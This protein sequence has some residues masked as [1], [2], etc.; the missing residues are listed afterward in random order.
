MAAKLLLF[1]EFSIHCGMLC[2]AWPSSG[3]TQYIWNIWEDISNI[4]CYKKKLQLIFT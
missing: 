3:I 1:S 4:K 2:L